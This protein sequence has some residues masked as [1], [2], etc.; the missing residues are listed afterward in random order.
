[1]NTHETKIYIGARHKKLGTLVWWGQTHWW[2]MKLV[3]WCVSNEIGR[4]FTRATELGSKRSG[5]TFD[6]NN[7]RKL[8]DYLSKIATNPKRNAR[9]PEITYMDKFNNLTAKTSI[10]VNLQ[11]ETTET[12]IFM[13]GIERILGFRGDTLM[14]IVFNEKGTGLEKGTD[15]C[16]DD[17]S[18]EDHEE[19][20]TTEPVNDVNDDEGDEEEEEEEE[21]DDEEP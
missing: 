3:A 9:F 5:F 10:S 2:F 17:G 13:T 14:H 20:Q 12:V 1:M 19:E 16:W 11:D 4:S 21:E 7:A 8:L 18:D 15:Y 6:R